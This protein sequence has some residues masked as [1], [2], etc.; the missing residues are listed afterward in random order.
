MEDQ[1]IIYAGSVSY[2]NM[3]RFNSGFFFKHELLLKYRGIGEPDVTFHC[4]L[5]FDPFK[6]MAAQGK[7]YAF[8]IAL[9]EWSATI[10]TL[11]DTVK[12]ELMLCFRER[13][14]RGGEEDLPRYRPSPFLWGACDALFS[15]RGRGRGRFASRVMG[16]ALLHALCR[17]LPSSFDAVLPY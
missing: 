10:P 9:Y 15:G 7:V 5:P 17:F 8:T 14:G 6:Y 11:W 1:G 16:R 12:G 13:E 2:R 4:T 3:C